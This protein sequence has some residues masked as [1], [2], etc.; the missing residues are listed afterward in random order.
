[1]T[2]GGPDVVAYTAMLH[3]YSTAGN[4]LTF[5]YATILR[6]VWVCVLEV[7]CDTEG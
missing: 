2:H 1:M 3:A 6:G 7:V 5:K 4:V